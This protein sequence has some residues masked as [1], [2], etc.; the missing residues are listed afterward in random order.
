[1]QRALISL[2]FAISCWLFADA[3]TEFISVNWQNLTALVVLSITLLF[4]VTKY[5]PDLIKSNSIER[6]EALKVQADQAKVFAQAAQQQTEASVRATATA[7]AEATKAIAT[8][9][10]GFTS[11]LDKMHGRYHDD[12]TAI[13]DAISSL[14]QHCASTGN[15]ATIH[16]L[17][18]QREEEHGK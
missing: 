5:L 13:V 10:E 15:G 17:R 6:T 2:P 14:A 12:N 3:S 11:T 18:R 7:S 4:L 9:H 8:M 1:M 16:T